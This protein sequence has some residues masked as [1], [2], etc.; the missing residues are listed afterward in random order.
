MFETFNTIAGKTLRNF[1]IGSC[2]VGALTLGGS[3]FE[4]AP[5]ASGVS[6]V[7]RQHD[8]VDQGPDEVSDGLSLTERARIAGSAELAAG[9]LAALGAIA[10]AGARQRRTLDQYQDRLN[11][12]YHTAEA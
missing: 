8:A 3:A 7:G 11:A 6:D 12:I 1:A 2:L 4:S 5:G 9:S 10:M